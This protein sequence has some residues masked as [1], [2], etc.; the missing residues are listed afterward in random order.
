MNK[1]YTYNI[2]LALHQSYHHSHS[3]CR[4]PMI[5]EYIDHCDIE[6]DLLHMVLSLGSLK[7]NNKNP[8][9]HTQ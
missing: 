5:A 7:N 9:I 4:T 2:L 6:I 8:L 3:L 1:I